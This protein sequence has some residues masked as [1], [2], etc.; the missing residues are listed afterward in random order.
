MG[1]TTL[2]M[3]MIQVKLLYQK[4]QIFLLMILVVDSILQD[5]LKRLRVR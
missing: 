1:F 4:L 3:Y 2:S 5:Q